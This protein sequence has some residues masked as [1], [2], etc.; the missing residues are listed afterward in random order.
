MEARSALFE[1]ARL[2]AA[3]ADAH[4]VLPVLAQA[5]V[6]I[7]GAAASAIFEV[8]TTGDAALVAQHGLPP[9][10]ST[11]TT[12]A[13]E[14]GPELARHVLAA[15]GQGFASARVLPMVSAGDI[16]GAVVLLFRSDSGLS[17]QVEEAARS[18]VDLAASA[19]DKAAKHAHIVRTHDQL[20]ASQ[21]TLL[22]TE[23]L[24]ALGEMAAGISHDLKNVVAPLSLHLQVARRA[25][26]R[27]QDADAAAAIVECESIVR[28]ASELLE[29]LRDFSRQQPESRIEQTD[30][31]RLATEATTIA[32]PRMASR[33]G[34][35]NEITLDLGAP[36]V[37]PTRSSEVLSALVNL[38]VNAI[39]AM[40]DG[41]EV[42]VR[43]GVND[44]RAF[45]SVADE[46]PG[47]SAEV[48]AKVFQPF[49]TTK[50]EKGTGLGLAMVY[51][52]MQR[53]GG[54]I[55]IDTAPGRGATFTLL[56]PI[57][58]EG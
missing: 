39:D 42:T 49:F 55:E 56:F 46:G 31:N 27:K 21:E 29:R 1:I 22:R 23:K 15:A 14:I 10:L 44:E 25:L 40:P 30:L 17:P 16:F 33:G 8:T 2:L 18:L 36:P 54:S 26:A 57:P 9:K 13:D 38:I 53:H 50:G 7:T 12:D 41:G 48:Q 58:V 43:S 5:A 19:M 35:L 47:M 28:R 52:C 6:T 4:G 32:R 20:R 51:A 45:V 34:R 37:V 3:S 11:F 24:R